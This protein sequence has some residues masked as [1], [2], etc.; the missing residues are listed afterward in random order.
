[1]ASGYLHPNDV[2]FYHPCDDLVEYKEGKTWVNYGDNLSFVDGIIVSG[3][4]RTANYDGRLE[5]TDAAYP[6]CSGNSSWTFAC[7]VKDDTA[8]SQEMWAGWYNGTSYENMLKLNLGSASVKVYISASGDNDDFTAQGRSP[9]GSGLYVIHVEFYG[10]T[11]SGWISHN[12]SGWIDCGSVDLGIPDEQSDRVMCGKYNYTGKVGN[13]I[14]DEVIFWQNTVQFTDAELLNLYN[15]FYEHG[16]TMDQYS[17]V[18]TPINDNA[19]LF[20]NGFSQVSRDISLYIP[21]QFETGSMPLYISS[22]FPVS[23]NLDSFIG[24]YQVSSGNMDQYVEGCLTTSGNITLYM[25]GV[26]TASSSL[27]LYTAGPFAA[28]NNIDDFIQ[29]HMSIS[30]NSPLFIKGNPP[31]FDAFVA[32]VEN[33]PSNSLSLFTYG[34][35]P[36][37]SGTFYTSNASALFISADADDNVIAIADWSAFARIDDVI[38]DSYSGTWSSFARVGYTANDNIDLYINSH[39]SGE[40]PHGTLI[41]NSLDTFIEGQGDSSSDGYFVARSVTSAF[42]K[43]HSGLSGTLDLCISGV[44]SPIQPSSGSFDLFTFG[45]LGIGS[46]SHTMYISG[47]GF[48]NNTCDLFVFGVLG[49]QSDNLPLYLEVTNIGSF[50]QVDSLYT[51]GY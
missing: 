51:H 36:G 49:I 46:G 34:V 13:A 11:A 27:S 38:P 31:D 7:W 5:S 43:V 10:S 37:V 30:G 50:N 29:G 40:N 32:V 28:N 16:L 33:S 12:G 21:G 26:P 44:L 22:P 15:L 48:T 18:G 24:G 9:T 20:V 45:I 35:I 47:E 17:T 39:A 8:Y 6:G 41:T 42:A 14:L 19:D 2:V 4:T 23:G 1:M 25:I 3:V